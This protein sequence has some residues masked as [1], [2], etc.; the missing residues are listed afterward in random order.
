MLKTEKIIEKAAV[1]GKESIFPSESVI[2]NVLF[3]S[4]GI[5][6]FPQKINQTCNENFDMRFELFAG[7]KLYSLV[8]R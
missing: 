2:I 4:Q 5:G 1:V 6:I 7:A 8:N 3:S